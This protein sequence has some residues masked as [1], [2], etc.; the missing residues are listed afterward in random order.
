MQNEKNVIFT[1]FM[2]HCCLFLL[3]F[4]P[5]LLTAG[6]S[7]TVAFTKQKKLRG[8][9][10]FFYKLVSLHP[11][12]NSPLEKKMLRHYLLGSGGVFLFNDADFKRLK[13]VVPRYATGTNC[14]PLENGTSGYCTQYVNLH[15][16]DYFGWGLGNLTVIY[17]DNDASIVSFADY[18][19]F[20]KKEKGKR[21]LK[22]EIVTRVF[23]LLAPASSRPFIVTY[24]AD[25]FVTP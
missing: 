4:I 10:Q 1:A 17:Q 9:H 22:N 24:G 23:R 25:A 12:L 2:K 14:K 18:Y 7:A 21:K 8:Y 5:S 19:D 13:E 16:D 15:D 20:D 3:L 11:K 6:D